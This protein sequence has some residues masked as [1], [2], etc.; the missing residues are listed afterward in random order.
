M[1]DAPQRRGANRRAQTLVEFAI[2]LPMLV[3]VLFSIIEMSYT[4]FQALTVQYA[5]R[6]GARQGA[7]G[8]S[9]PQVRSTILGLCS[10]FGIQGT[11]IVFV[12]TNSLGEVQPPVNGQSP[13]PP[14]GRIRVTTTHKI[15]F[16]TFMSS[17]MAPSGTLQ[18]RPFTQLLIE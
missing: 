10:N 18:I 9:D 6:V 5:T 11:D 8:K 14:G 2:V 15:K 17:V 3:M 1:S 12:V 16:L 4:L 7:V 13:R